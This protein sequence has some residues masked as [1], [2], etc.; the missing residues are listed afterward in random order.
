MKN[1]WTKLTALVIAA[2]WSGPTVQAQAPHPERI[3]LSGTGIDDTRTWEFFCSGGQNSGKWKKIEVPCNW[4]LQG[5]G[6]YT[7]G[8]WYT[9]KGERPSDET[10]IYR[11]KFESPATTSGERIKIFFDGVMTDTEVF[12]NGKPAGEMH[13]GGFYR[14]S[15]DITDLLKPGK[16]NLLEVKIA[17][18][19]ANK[20][21]NAAERKADWWLYGGIYRPVWLEVVPAV[22]M[23]HFILNAD[24]HGKLQAAIEMEGDAKGY[25]LSVSVRS[26]KDGLKSATKPLN[27]L[28][29]F[30]RPLITEFADN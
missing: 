26:L 16:K 21:I 3:Y 4:E 5:F 20:S 15:Y 14:F 24:Q 8:R 11:Y 2:L 19:S 9:I 7:Y 28:I 29:A 30:T 10:G 27:V 13:Q 25:E 6:E 22:H 23:R 1:K 17:K 12:I 18:E